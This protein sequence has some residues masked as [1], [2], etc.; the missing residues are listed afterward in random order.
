MAREEHAR[1][2]L[3]AEATALV[4]R[5]ELLL[6]GLPEPV[7][8][9]FRPDGSASLFFTDDPVYQFNSRG[10]LRR[11]FVGGRLYKADAGR[12]VEMTRNRPAGQV[13]LTSRRLPAEASA[14]FIA[15]L[16]ARLNDLASQLESGQAQILAEVPPQGG[17]AVRL[18]Q[19]LGA[20][21]GQIEIATTPHAR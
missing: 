18:G 21:R 9:G 5:V 12:L 20:L 15:A 7:V 2:N 11:A 10:H 16:R 17:V 14:E 13:Q 8:A 19:W 6:A 3:I 4:E 1:E